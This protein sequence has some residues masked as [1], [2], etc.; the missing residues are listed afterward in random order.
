MIV[1]KGQGN[2]ETLNNEDDRMWFLLK[3]K[4]PVLAADLGCGVGELVV[5]PGPAL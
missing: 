5:R 2:C 4:C 3:V 1:S